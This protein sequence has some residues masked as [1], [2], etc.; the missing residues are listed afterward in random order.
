[1]IFVGIL[2][3]IMVVL[4]LLQLA[5]TLGAPLGRFSAG[6]QHRVFPPR[7][8]VLSVVSI[9]IYGLIVVIAWDKVGLIDVFPTA[10][11]DIAMWVVFGYLTLGI[12]MNAISRSKAERYTMVPVSIVLSVLT[13][14]IAMGWAQVPVLS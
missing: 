6:G 4:A 9:L 2:T 12:L 13:F 11:T 8:R 14:V 10:F 7:L 3:A 5:L 1:M